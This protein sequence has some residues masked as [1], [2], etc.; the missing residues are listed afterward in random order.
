MSAHEHALTFSL[1]NLHVI[2][3]GLLVLM[4]VEVSGPIYG[5][6]RYTHL[7]NLGVCFI[8]PASR[9]VLSYAG[10][11]VVAYIGLPVVLSAVF[12]TKVVVHAARGSVRVALMSHMM[13]TSG[14][15]LWLCAAVLLSQALLTPYHMLLMLGATSRQ[16]PLHFSV[17][18]HWM[19]VV[20]MTC[21]YPVV[22]V[23]S[24][25]REMTQQVSNM[26]RYLQLYFMDRESLEEELELA[27]R[28]HH[29]QRLYVGKSQSKRCK[30]TNLRSDGD[31]RNDIT[32]ARISSGAYSPPSNRVVESA[33]RSPG[34]C[35]VRNNHFSTIE[36]RKRNLSFS[37]SS[38]KAGHFPATSM[39]RGVFKTTATI[40]RNL[41][42]TNF[43]S[44]RANVA[45]DGNKTS[46][47]FGSD[48]EVLRN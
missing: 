37:L 45:T 25:A 4:L 31:K 47:S 7:Q 17:T 41:K 23:I 38:E 19:H 12:V 20:A 44:T 30:E 28:H 5:W 21:V 24:L 26:R 46:P 14:T 11:H 35:L 10:I 22:L 39:R 40:E 33:N 1:L 29:R 15:V 34:N 13:H 43:V 8:D 42:E 32:M 2:M 48:I 16:I 9:H 3:A 18:A 36:E 6:A 27:E